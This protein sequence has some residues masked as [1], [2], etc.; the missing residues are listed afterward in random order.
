MYISPPKECCCDYSDCCNYTCTQTS[1]IHTCL[2][3]DKHTSSLAHTASRLTPWAAFSLTSTRCSLGS[4][5]AVLMLNGETFH[6]SFV[7]LYPSNNFFWLWQWLI[8]M[9]A[10]QFLYFWSDVYGKVGLSSVISWWQSCAWNRS[11]FSICICS[12]SPHNVVHS[13]S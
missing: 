9:K 3:A 6:C 13:S 11:M 2:H 7:I 12:G 1:T 10:L 4:V 5:H 8:P